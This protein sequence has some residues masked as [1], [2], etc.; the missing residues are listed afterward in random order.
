MEDADFEKNKAKLL[1]VLQAAKGTH[2]DAIT[3]S[4]LRACV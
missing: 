1:R 2:I 4:V 3:A